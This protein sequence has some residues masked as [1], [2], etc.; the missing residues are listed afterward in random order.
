MLDW[1][2]RVAYW[3]WDVLC[4]LGTV[5]GPVLFTDWRSLLGVLSCLLTLLVCYSTATVSI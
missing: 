2:S 1:R 5:V 3:L 4:C